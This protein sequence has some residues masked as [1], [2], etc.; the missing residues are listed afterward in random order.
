MLVQRCLTVGTAWNADSVIN[1]V[2]TAAAD[3]A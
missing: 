2:L 1:H 3:D